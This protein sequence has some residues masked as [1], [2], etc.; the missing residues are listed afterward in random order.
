MI[1]ILVIDDDKAICKHLVKF[2]SEQLGHKATCLTNPL[3]A[4][5]VIEKEAPHIVLLDVFMKE[6]NG[7]DLLRQIKQ[8]YGN[9]VKVIMITVAGDTDELKAREFGADDFIRKPFDRE[10]LRGVVM[11][12][13]QEVLGFKRKEELPKKDIPLVLIVDDETETVEEIEFFLKRVIECTI[14]TAS[15]GKKASELM[16]KNDYDLVFL[17]IKMP[18]FSGFDV[19]KNVKAIKPLPDILVITGYVDGDV[20]EQVKKEGAIGYIPKPIYLENF[21]KQIKNILSKKK[22]Y[23]EKG[24]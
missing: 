22:K 2:L 15:D 4:V 24:S 8:K 16:Q 7:L 12:K 13:L 3:E 19:M 18:G 14:D 23:F 10:Y 5:A 20:G 21:K 17:D 6:M 11:V 1:K 9:T